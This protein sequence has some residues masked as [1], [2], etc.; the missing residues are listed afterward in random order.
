MTE[1]I[2]FGTDGWRAII[3]DQFTFE[4]VERVAYAVGTYIKKEYGLTDEK[5]AKSKPILIGYDTRFLADKFAERAGQILLSMGLS[6]RITERDV[7]TPCIAFAAQNEP[8]CGALQITA[9]HNPPEY[10]GVKYIPHFGGP[11]T[12]ETTNEITKHLSDLPKDYEFG[13]NGR[14]ALMREAR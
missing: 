9:S 4:N 2:K 8:T 5:S 13:R 1:K 3:A 7:P 10:C 11:A 12:N 14:A 6:A